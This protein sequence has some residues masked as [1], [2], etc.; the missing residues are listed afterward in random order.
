[1]RFILWVPILV[2]W[3]ALTALFSI[4]QFGAVDRRA[5]LLFGVYPDS[6]AWVAGSLVIFGIGAMFMAAHAARRFHQYAQ[7]LRPSVPS[8]DEDVDASTSVVAPEK[9]GF[10]R[11]LAN[12]MAPVFVASVLLA[13]V[14][15]MAGF[16]FEQG[17]E[18]VESATGTFDYGV[19]QATVFSDGSAQCHL[20]MD[21]VPCVFAYR[22]EPFLNDILAVQDSWGVSFGDLDD[23]GSDFVFSWGRTGNFLTV[24]FGDL[25]SASDEMESSEPTVEDTP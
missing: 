22:G 1:M 19:V 6:V 16:S 12:A 20:D 24:N 10:W 7:S 14:V 9:P 21:E 2:T 5:E 15:V 3:L 17:R 4:R 11:T 25:N 23:S 8:N 18:R 13:S